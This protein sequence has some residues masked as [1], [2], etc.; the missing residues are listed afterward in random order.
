MRA[1]QVAANRGVNCSVPALSEVSFF[2]SKEDETG[3]GTIEGLDLSD[4]T[5]GLQ[6]VLFNAGANKAS[7]I[8][9][10]YS[11]YVK[12][13]NSTSRANSMQLSKAPFPQAGRRRLTRL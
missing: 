1:E 11:T 7:K 6:G 3:S 8:L 2:A 4:K 9:T 13:Q 10:A 5:R 12:R